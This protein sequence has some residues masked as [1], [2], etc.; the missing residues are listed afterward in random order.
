MVVGE[1]EGDPLLLWSLGTSSNTSVASGIQPSAPS[2]PYTSPQG[3]GN[4]VHQQLWKDR[5]SAAPQQ[6]TRNMD[7]LRCQLS[8][9]HLVLL[10]W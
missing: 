7:L 1:G 4:S 9:P 3:R 8:Y 6:E 2:R 10:S 5:M